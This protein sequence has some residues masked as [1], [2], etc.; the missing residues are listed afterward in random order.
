MQPDRVGY[1]GASVTRIGEEEYRARQDRLRA[2]ALE[3]GLGAVVAWSRGGGTQDRSADVLYLTGFYTPQPFVPDLRGEGLE[4]WRW[5]AAGHAAAVVEA[6]GPVRMVVHGERLQGPAPVADSIVGSADPVDTVLE[7]LEGRVESKRVGLL[8][9]DALP[10]RWARRLEPRIDLVEADELGWTLR[11]V[12]SPAERSLL[13]ASGALGARAIEAAMLAAVPGASEAHVAATLVG[14]VVRG[15]GAVYDVVLSS[16][17]WADTL[18]PSGGSAGTAGYTS[19]RLAAGDLLR[20]DAYGSLGGYLFDLARSRVVGQPPSE[21]QRR[22]LDAVRDS[23][24]AG[25]AAVSPGVTLGGRGR[26]LRGRSRRLRVHAGVRHA[27]VHDGRRVGARARPRFRAALDR[28]GLRRGG[29][30]GHVLGDRAP[31]RGTRRGWC[32]V[33]GRSV[34]RPHGTGAPDSCPR[35][36]RPP[37]VRERPPRPGE[38]GR[39][40]L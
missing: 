3:S 5:R 1:R 31:H 15:G 11:T 14:E 24:E 29:R 23:V 20:I 19:R 34:G 2:L 17:E 26:P 28:S 6:D 32:P 13:R 37:I 30:G 9:G 8:G 22:L 16:G 39:S 36:I 18:A 35:R 4:E 7:L 21:T 12:K 40:R 33:R 27:G 38:P 10:G 25:I